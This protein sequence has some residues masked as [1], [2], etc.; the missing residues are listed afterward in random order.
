MSS[1]GGPVLGDG[2]LQTRGLPLGVKRH[3]T[4]GVSFKI[5]LRSRILPCVLARG[6][7]SAG[8][9]KDR[10]LYRESGQHLTYCVGKGARRGANAIAISPRSLEGPG[11]FCRVQEEQIGEL[12]KPG[13]VLHD[14]EHH[15]TTEHRPASMVLGTKRKMKSAINTI[16]HLAPLPDTSKS[17]RQVQNKFSVMSA[18]YPIM[19]RSTRGRNVTNCW[20]HAFVCITNHPEAPLQYRPQ[21]RSDR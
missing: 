17:S 11:A 5:K 10:K 15:M 14:V 4:H 6:C 16:I 12:E 18:A 2:A 13:E 1:R 19:M 7:L 8:S 21:T 9:S 3:P 20:S